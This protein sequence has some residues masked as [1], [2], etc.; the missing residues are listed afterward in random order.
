MKKNMEVYWKTE[1]NKQ[2]K[3]GCIGKRGKNGG[4]AWSV[5]VRDKCRKISLVGGMDL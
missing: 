4:L 2:Q 5:W 3:Q 1:E